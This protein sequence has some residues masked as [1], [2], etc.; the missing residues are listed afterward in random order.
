[1]TALLEVEALVAGYGGAPVL[2]GLDLSV[3]LDQPVA[4]VGPNGAGKSTLIKTLMGQLALMSGTVR[5][6][7][8]DLTACSVEDRAARGLALVPEGRRIFAGLTVR[9]NLEVATRRPR[10]VRQSAVAAI[11]DLFPVLA[12]KSG[13]RA[14]Q[15][16]GGQQQML[17]IGRAMMTD[18]KMILMDEPTLGLAP[19]TARDVIAAIGRLGVGVLIAEQNA[20][21]IGALEAHIL[22]LDGGIL[23]D[24]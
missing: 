13:Q 1:M 15:L 19:G 24:D 14:W 12:E 9:E 4:V 17:A 2:R 6:A 11:F 21:R 8:Q 18:P 23:A 20:S 5:F 22:R 10:A 16:S 7:G 3:V